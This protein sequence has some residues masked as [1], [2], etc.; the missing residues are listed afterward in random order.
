MNA[1]KYLLEKNANQVDEVTS[2]GVSHTVKTPYENTF[3]KTSSIT[4]KVDLDQLSRKYEQN[5][6][7]QQE[8]VKAD[9]NR[10][11]AKTVIIEIQKS[12]GAAV[13]DGLWGNK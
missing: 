8:T 3:A 13:V 9:S 2:Q 10:D 7:V 6:K 12:I 5:L 4:N 11:F 1:C